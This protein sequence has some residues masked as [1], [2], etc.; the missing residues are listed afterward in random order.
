M[1]AELGTV[2]TG[3]AWQ[4]EAGQHL[5]SRLGRDA[6]VFVVDDPT[7]PGRLVAIGAGTI[8]RRLPGPHNPG[9]TAGYIQWIFTEPAWRRR[10]LAR[11]VTQAVL[12]WFRENEVHLVELHAYP[13]AEALYRSLGFQEGHSRALRARI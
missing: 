11:Q 6:A 13:E 3:G 10:G 1:Y 12:D 4:G 2:P 8:A 9:A 5:A 7:A